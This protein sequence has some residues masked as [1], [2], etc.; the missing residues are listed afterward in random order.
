MTGRLSDYIHG[1]R[2]AAYSVAFSPDGKLL[3]SGSEDRTIKLWKVATGEELAALEGHT[4][5]V[6]T[7][8]F[9]ADGTVLASGGADRTVKLW[10]V[11]RKWP[12]GK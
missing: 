12:D 4:G 2:A 7:V 3:A 9:N 8:A 11:P 10:D 1:H 5:H 6:L